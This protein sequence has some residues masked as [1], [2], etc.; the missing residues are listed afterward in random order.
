[1]LGVKTDQGIC[2]KRFINMFDIR[3]LAICTT[4]FGNVFYEIC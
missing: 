3:D 1:M 4:R 2:Y